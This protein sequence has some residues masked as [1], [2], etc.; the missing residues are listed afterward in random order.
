MITQVEAWSSW[1]ES[2]QHVPVSRLVLRDYWGEVV[3]VP[4]PLLW[5]LTN[6]LSLTPL[7]PS[8]SPLAPGSG[9]EDAVG[10][11]SIHVEIFTHPNNGEHKV[12][13]KGRSGENG[14]IRFTR[15]YTVH[16]SLL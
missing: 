15:D 4:D 5:V 3:P 16:T 2:S 9:V 8:P 7:A 10:E 6:A 13:V 11:V 14:I 1:L 12:T